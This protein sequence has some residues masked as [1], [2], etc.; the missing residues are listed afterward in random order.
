MGVTDLRIEQLA[1]QPTAVVERDVPMADIGAAIGGAFQAVFGWLG[2]HGVVPAGMPFARYLE[3]HDGRTR[4]E[5]G[6]AVAGAVPA[7]SDV[8]AATLPG[9]DVAMLTYTGPYEGIAAAYGE[10]I[11]WVQAQGRAPAGAMWELYFTDPTAE[12]DPAK[13]RTDICQPLA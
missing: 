10:L 7:G 2:S 8:H 3:M 11:Q 5:A 4:L 1:A 12:P 6:V 9:G 13:W